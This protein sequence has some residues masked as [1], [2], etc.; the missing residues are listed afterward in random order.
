[1]L[2]T[3]YTGLPGCSSSYQHEFE[4]CMNDLGAWLQTCDIG[5]TNTRQVLNRLAA[6]SGGVP[7]LSPTF[8]R[9]MVQQAIDD[10]LAAQGVSSCQLHLGCWVCQIVTCTL[11]AGYVNLLAAPCMLCVSNS[12]M[13]LVCWMCIVV[14]CTLFVVCVKQSLA[15]LCARCVKLSLTSCM[16]CFAMS[17]RWSPRSH[18]LTG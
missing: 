14:S 15:L 10:R 5:Q 3:L 11:Y 17:N 2:A 6:F 13:H 9:Q 16:S 7:G 12:H 8:T 18:A 4:V 1:M